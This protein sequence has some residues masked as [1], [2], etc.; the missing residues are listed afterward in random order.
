MAKSN[1]SDETHKRAPVRDFFAPSLRV[2]GSVLHRIKGA[3]A[4][5]RFFDL[6][7]STLKKIASG[8]MQICSRGCHRGDHIVKI[9]DVETITCKCTLAYDN[10]IVCVAFSPDGSTI[11]AGEGSSQDSIATIF[12][13]RLYDA[14]TGEVNST[15]SGK[16]VHSS[17]VLSLSF[18]PDGKQIAS[19]SLDQ[20]VRIW[21]V[22]NGTCTCTVPVHS[23]VN[24]VAYSPC[25]SKIAAGCDD[26]IKI[27]SAD[28]AKVQCTLSGHSKWY[29]CLTYSCLSVA[30][31]LTS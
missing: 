8:T 6:L 2:A 7:L 30:C 28:T 29:V 14:K 23:K 4:V 17:V 26:F 5:F 19:G 31:V 22:K 10:P 11:A 20:T 3:D 15:L 27:I 24:C 1:N 9:W 13:I 25:G 12:D 21:D 16:G 18:S